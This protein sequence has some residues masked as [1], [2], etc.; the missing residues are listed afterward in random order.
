MSSV[1][2]CIHFV[3]PYLLA[4]N[5]P[6]REIS[7]ATRNWSTV[8]LEWKPPLP[9]QQNGPI[10]GYV[11]EVIQVD[12]GALGTSQL[13][14]PHRTLNVSELCTQVTGLQP[15]SSYSFVVTAGTVAGLGPGSDPVVVSAQDLGEFFKFIYFGLPSA[16]SSGCGTI[17]RV[18]SIVLD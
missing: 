7:V 17:R 14:L 8:E 9:T 11:V 4:P 5:G 6:P 2:V 18:K 16:S 3:P 10:T 1:C 15:F 13:S 12:A